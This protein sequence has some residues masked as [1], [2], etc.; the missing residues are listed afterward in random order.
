MNKITT[1]GK[2]ASDLAPGILDERKLPDASFD[3][4]WDSIILDKELKDRLLCQA[5][6]NF[7]I[8][9]NVGREVIP[10]HGVILLVGQPGTGKS[11]LAR[12][13]ASQVAKHLSSGPT[14]LEVEPHGLTSS[15]MG[16]TQRAVTE[17]LGSTISEYA[18]QGPVIVLLDE[19]E[20][21][22]TDRKKLSMDANPIDVHRATDAVLAQLDHLADR[23]DNLLFI[24][25]SNFEGAVDEAFISR[26]DLVLQIP[27]PNADARK[28]ILEDTI[29]G[30]AR[31]YPSVKQILHDPDF[32]RL[33][34]ATD[35]IDGRQLRKLV[36]TACSFRRETA[37]DPS[38]LTA[39]DILRAAKLD[40]DGGLAAKGKGA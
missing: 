20:T 28:S 33:V 23:Y 14:F 11:S 22:A 5:I 10:M 21:L 16:K 35:G 38:K 18:E 36:A 17:L 13:L 29:T 37:V 24:A 6:L 12:G 39:A 30:L 32:A 2:Y 34:V 15:A 1:S 26:S 27:M 9:K 31:K 40:R 7:T 19:V 8:R 4:V 3:R 25:T